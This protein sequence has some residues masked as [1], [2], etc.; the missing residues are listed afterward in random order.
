MGKRSA[1]KWI[2]LLFLL[3]LCGILLWKVGIPLA[4]WFTSAENR[5]HFLDVDR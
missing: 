3:A 4:V 2:L 1:K 5:N